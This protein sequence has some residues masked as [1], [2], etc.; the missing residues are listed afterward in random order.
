MPDV[1][2]SYVMYACTCTIHRSRFNRKN[3][4]LAGLWF[5]RAKPT[6]TTFLGPFVKELNLL[7]TKGIHFRY[8]S[9]VD[10]CLSNVLV[11]I[12]VNTPVGEVT[13][14]AK[15]LMF[16]ADLPAR[17]LVLNMKQYNGKFGCAHCEDEGQTR[18]TSHLHRNWPFSAVS[19]PRTHDG[20]IKNAKDA[21]ESREP[22]SLSSS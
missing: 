16:V 18:A 3:L 9:M 2:T 22:V 6:M 8:I 19:V 13:A 4:P 20:I 10:H 12:V 5:D 21:L 17:A 1:L 14:R 7:L 15:L 11:G